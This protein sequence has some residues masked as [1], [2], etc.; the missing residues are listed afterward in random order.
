LVRA[1]R[2]CDHI[3]AV[4]D[5]IADEL[6]FLDPHFRRMD[7]DLVYNGL[8]T[9]PVDMQHKKLSQERMRT[10]ASNLFGQ[11]PTWVFSHVARPVLSKG[12]W[13]DVGVLHHLDGLLAQRK[14]TAV[15]FMLGTLG[16]QR[17]SQ[18]IRHMERVYGWPVAHEVGYPDLCGGEEVLG[19]MFDDFNRHHQAVRVVLVN[20]WDWNNRFCGQRMPEDMAFADIRAGT[21]L[22]FGLSVYEPFGISQFEPLS[23]G[24]I[25]V[26]SNVCGCMGFARKAAAGEEFENIIQADYL[27]V[28]AAMSTEQLLG[29]PISARDKVELEEN[30]RLAGIIIG[31]LPRD[32]E[33]LQRRMRTGYELARRMSWERVVRE[34]FLPSLG[35]A[36]TPALAV[37][38]NA[39]IVPGRLIE[40]CGAHRVF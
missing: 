18:D 34:Y 16:G 28:S 30:R 23:F 17:R 20:Q 3:F 38:R 6:R 32:T 40:P 11:R 10:Y 13:R 33:V 26:V 25:C 37:G 35:R 15:Y 9:K 19:E 7:I 14:E 22:E 27:G 39:A 8:P 24:G 1:A 31:R 29:L 5:Y 21:D 12:I 36:A 2:Y 4:G